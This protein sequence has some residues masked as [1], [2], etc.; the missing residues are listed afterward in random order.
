[1]SSKQEWLLLTC[2]IVWVL[3]YKWYP[4]LLN[5]PLNGDESLIYS[6]ALTLLEI[7]PVPYRSVEFS[8]LGPLQVISFIIPQFLGQ[9]VSFNGFRWVWVV[10][11]IISQVFIYLSLKNFFKEKP[12]FVYFLYP[13]I[14]A[15]TTLVYDF[16]YFNNEAT[17]LVFLSAGLYFFS[18]NFEALKHKDSYDFWAV[19]LLSLSVYGKPHAAL[20]GIALSVLVFI[21]KYRSQ[22]VFTAKYILGFTF[23]GLISTA[24][25]FS[26]FAYFGIFEDFWFFYITTNLSYGTSE[27]FYNKFIRVFLTRSV[28]EHY[29]NYYVKHFYFVLFAVNLILPV[30]I[31]KLDFRHIVG[32][33]L[34]LVSIYSI[35]LPGNIYG[36]YFT[37]LFLT[38]GYSI[39]NLD[40]LV[41]QLLPEKFK[42]TFSFSVLAV[43]VFLFYCS[44][45]NQALYYT[46]KMDEL[47]DKKVNTLVK[48]PLS[49]YLLNYAT[50]KN[51]ENP[52]MVIF[53]WRNEIHVET[54][55]LQATHY[56]VPERLFG[57]QA[58]KPKVVERVRELYL[59]DI[60]KSKPAF[61]LLATSTKYS[62]WDMTM[63]ALEQ[64]P[65]LHKY[66]MEHYTSIKKIDDCDVFVRNDLNDA[67]VL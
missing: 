16:N 24:L 61:F 36:H 27:S 30:L 47:F 37:L 20:I 13:F 63:T 51:L 4:L 15:S 35:C 5:A 28:S 56:N 52:R 8:T 57:N 32:L 26:Y 14:L 60:K 31:R 1:M 41:R 65:D 46:S 9:E 23:S 18:K 44:L 64:V 62:Y 67:S 58:A 21:Q 2:A 17:C 40:A 66:V 49:K 3:I 11:L 43:C 48:A 39:G 7:D 10:Y 55:F 54:G 59:N 42:T 45:K 53:D 34:S 50:K 38:F 6:N 12:Y 33:V 25:I 19:F 29:I 22:G